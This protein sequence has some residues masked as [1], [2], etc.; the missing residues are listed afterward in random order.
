M[1][2]KPVLVASLTSF[3]ERKPRLWALTVL[4]ERWRATWGHCRERSGI[5]PLLNTLEP[6][7]SVP[8]CRE[9]S[10]NAQRAD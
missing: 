7:P 4:S 9:D 1:I 8:K 3:T 10:K 2:L 6:R 5:D